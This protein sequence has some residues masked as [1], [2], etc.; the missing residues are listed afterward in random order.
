MSGFTSYSKDSQDKS[1][2]LP[3]INCPTFGWTYGI[4]WVTVVLALIGT[5]ISTVGFFIQSE[6]IGKQ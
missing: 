1:G 3:E 4:V 2:C 5:V 6:R